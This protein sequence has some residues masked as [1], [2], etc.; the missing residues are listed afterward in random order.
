MKYTR[1]NNAKGQVMLVVIL[2][3]TVIATTIVLGVVAPIFRQI[4]NSRDMHASKQSYFTAE[5]G[6]EDS[7]YRMRNNVAITFPQT[8]VLGSATATTTLEP[9]SNS[10]QQ[11]ISEGNYNN[12][13]R[14]V[15]KDLTV[16]EGG[17]SFNFAVQVGI[18]GIDMQNQSSIIGNVYSNGPITGDGASGLN[19]NYISESAVS[20]GSSGIIDSVRVKKDAYAHSIANAIIDSN[21]YYQTIDQA[22]TVGGTKYPN[23]IDKEAAAMPISDATIDQ[24]ETTAAA[25]G[26]ITTPCTITTSVSLGTKKINCA[27]FTV[28]GNDAV[29]NV[30]GALWIT[31]N[32]V[33]K[34]GGT[35]KVDD[36]VGN[37]T[38]PIVVDNPS[39]R[40]T[41]S[42]ALL[43]NNSYF[44][45]ATGFLDSYVM[46]VSRN[47][48]AES[49]GITLAFDIRNN[50]VGNVL[51]YAPHGKMQIQNNPVIREATAH[52]LVLKNS[53]QVQYTVGLAQPLFTSGPGG[54]WKVKRWKEI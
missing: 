24:W 25:G 39:N 5:S 33:V 1:L 2:T 46:I 49:G 34:N 4:Q 10:E 30:T 36:A 14:S 15:V 50:V 27:T 31:G 17:F 54:K 20:V 12:L 51:L 19:P 52:T 40:S 48:S 29:L 45:G 42:T 26:T 13:I 44:Y 3:F 37:K 38:V 28:D 43:Q 23:S 21:A 16:S 41:G 22:T 18:G 6:S 53:A 8:L 9:L 11:I 7:F 47:T 35:V 32:L